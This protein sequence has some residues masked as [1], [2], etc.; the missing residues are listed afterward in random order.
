M[1]C[2]IAYAHILIHVNNGIT[3]FLIFFRLMIAE[4]YL[5]RFTMPHLRGDPANK[6]GIWLTKGGNTANKKGA[7]NIGSL[8][9]G[10]NALAPS[11]G[12]KDK[13]KAAASFNFKLWIASLDNKRYCEATPF[14][15]PEKV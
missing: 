1:A 15:E 4:Y 13:K 9:K 14:T 7:T 3:N 2:P 10:R 5:I 12:T 11:G 8:K 6:K